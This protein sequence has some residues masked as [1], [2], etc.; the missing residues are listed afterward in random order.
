VGVGW[1]A[2]K[3]MAASKIRLKA[4]KKLLLYIL[5][6]FPSHLEGD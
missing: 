6:S 5:I 2:L 3:R 4:A 1:Q